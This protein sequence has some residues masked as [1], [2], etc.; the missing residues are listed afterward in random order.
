SFSH[1]ALL[2]VDEKSGAASVIESHIECGVKTSSFADY[3]Q[4]KK[5]RILALRLRADLPAMR[6][7]PML[8]HAAASA[9]LNDSGHRHIP[10]DFAMDYRDP[11]KQFCSEVASAAYGS[12][13]IHLW[14]GP[15]FISDPVVSAWLASVGVRHFETQAPA[16][17]EYDPQ[18]RVVAEWRDRAALL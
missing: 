1:V 3:L 2:Y 4:D 5:L 8:P 6:T 12:R 11:E 13:N 16:D 18:L 9:A 15:T 17:L 14:T 7:D 10:Y